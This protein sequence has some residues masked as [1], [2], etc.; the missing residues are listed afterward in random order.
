MPS[1][2]RDE[3]HV[4]V[5]LA[6]D[7][8][9]KGGFSRVRTADERGVSGLSNHLLD[10]RLRLRRR[11]HPDLVDAAP[12]VSCAALSP[13]PC[14]TLDWTDEYG[15]AGTSHSASYALA[16][17][18]LSRTY[19]GATHAVARNV[20]EA[21]FSLSGSLITV[22]VTSTDSDLQSI[23]RQFTHYFHLRPH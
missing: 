18:V 22:T 7:P 23:S 20:D 12:A 10:F 1:L 9:E 17:R 15:G 5:L 4:P 2:L 16:G 8:V 13:A 6:D 3:Q 21:E 19:D 11:P 14:V